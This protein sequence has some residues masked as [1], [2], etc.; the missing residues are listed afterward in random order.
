MRPGHGQDSARKAAHNTDD[1]ERTGGGMTIDKEFP[2]LAVCLGGLLLAGCVMPEKYEAEKARS[3]N[4][5]RLLAQ[6]EKRT[7]DLD[8]EI[9]RV[10]RE[11]SEQEARNRE[12]AA[13][14]KAVREQLVGV[15]EETN[16][17]RE[18]AALMEK[19]REDLRRSR[20][21]ALRSKRFEKATVAPG[22]DQFTPALETPKAE[23]SKG[24]KAETGS[25]VYH[26]VRPG[27]TLFR[28]SRQHGIEVEQIKEWNNLH[29][30]LIEVGQTLIVGYQ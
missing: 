5:Q 23:V 20:Q 11:A 28:L 19:S 22:A 13:Q 16:A 18:A 30:D 7:G 10:K 27:E 29:D 17:L 24:E 21:P 14:L 12:M 6:E 2:L 8:S 1:H 15:Q 3:L 25:P 9:K 26:E 4:F